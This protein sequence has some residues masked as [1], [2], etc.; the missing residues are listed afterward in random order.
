[1]IV[2]DVMTRTV[3]TATPRTT[4]HELVDLMVRHGVSGLPIVDEC[5]RPIG[6]VSEADLVAKAAFGTA[7]HRLLDVLTGRVALAPGRWETKAEGVTADAIMSAPAQ[8]VRSADQ[9]SAAAAHMVSTGRKRLPVVDAGGHLVGIISR[10]DILRLFHRTDEE[11]TLDVA[12]FLDDPL[13]G[14]GEADVTV[15]VHDGI[16]SLRGIECGL[17]GERVA[18]AIRHHVPGVVDVVVEA[19]DAGHER[20]TTWDC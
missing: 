13:A 20:G 3:V 6:V 9:V 7:R 14:L 2:G 19:A 16:V 18:A 11:L 15:A 10:S 8:T 5:N 12:R 1:M 17:G 4:F